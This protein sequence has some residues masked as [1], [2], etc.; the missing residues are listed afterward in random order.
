MNSKRKI[1]NRLG[2]SLVEIAIALPTIGIL[3][4]GMCSAVLLSVRAVPQEGSIMTAS[5]EAAR[6][7]E[8]FE[9]DA[10]CATQVS[11]SESRE[12]Q[13]T[14]PDRTGDGTP[15]IIRYWW[16][17]TAGS[18]IYRQINNGDAET[19]LQQAETFRLQY[20]ITDLTTNKVVQNTST[21]DPLLL[22]SFESWPGVTPAVNELSVASKDWI[23]TTFELP[24]TVP[25]NYSRLRF[26]R[27][28]VFARRGV[29][30]GSVRAGVYR[31]NSLLDPQMSFPLGSTTII[32][33]SA[34]PTTWEWI[35]TTLSNDAV[36]TDGTRTFSLVFS[37]DGAVPPMQIRYLTSE[38]A[39]NEVHPTARW[40]TDSGNSWKPGTGDY[41]KNDM[42][43]RIYGVYETVQVALVQ[44]TKQHL[45]S[46]QIELRSAS[47]QSVNIDSTVALLNQPAVVP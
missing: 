27:A 23:G 47:N 7:F 29:P 40:T 41:Y 20:N 31:I 44:E 37:S 22:A 21:S 10:R 33:P 2:S 9:R 14:V 3:T 5:V 28:E 16:S 13:F 6:L 18:S 30:T 4:V 25:R 17:G 38:S 46:V 36:S 45:T 24:N 8:Q 34:L 15:D 11:I 35:Q 43:F 32:T 42:M 12:F 19:V 1:G 39:P 26:T